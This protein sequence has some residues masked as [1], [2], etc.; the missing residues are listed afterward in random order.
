M[1]PIQIWLD[2]LTTCNRQEWQYQSSIEEARYGWI[3]L[4]T[5]I[6]KN[7]SISHQ[8]R[9]PDMIGFTYILQ[10]SRMTVSAIDRG[11]THPD[12]F[13]FTYSLQSSRMTVSAIDR[14]ETR[15]DMVGF[16]YILQS[17]GMTVSAINREN[18]I[19]I[20][21][22]SL[23]ALPSIEA[24]R[25]LTKRDIKLSLRHHGTKPIVLHRVRA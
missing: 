19:Q 11:E 6:V 3:H 22:D 2:S 25:N 23:A 18:P 7:D 8:S 12:I 9:R 16:T 10:S 5:A 13:G 4:H 20:C 1:R 15:P 14:G 17:S 21:L 24:R